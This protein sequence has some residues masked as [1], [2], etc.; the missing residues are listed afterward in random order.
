[1][2]VQGHDIA[3]YE[4]LNLG[5]TKPTIFDV[6]ANVGDMTKLFRRIWP[7]SR[8]ICFEPNPA[9]YRRLDEET[10]DMENVQVHGCGLSEEPGVAKLHFAGGPDESASLHRRD[11]S[12]AGV[13]LHPHIV[14]VEIR[15]LSEYLGGGEVDLLKLDAEGHELAILRGAGFLLR[16]DWVKRIA[17]EFNSCNLDSRTFLK[18]F[19]D[20]LVVERGYSLF[21]IDSGGEV[22]LVENYDPSLEDFAAHREFIA[23]G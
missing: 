22:T 15:A 23:T 10:F 18:D 3:F 5:T 11:L 8:I 12:Y 4:K 14:T 13:E 6:G 21:Q 19:W 16:P 20:L 2:S 1:V 7:N 9:A 17:F